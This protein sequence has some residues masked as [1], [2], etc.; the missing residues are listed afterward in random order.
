MTPPGRL[1]VLAAPSGV[2]KTTI[3]RALAE[4]RRDVGFSVSATTRPPRSG[5]RDGVDYHFLTAADF[6]RRVQ[7]GDF[8]EFAD[9][10][11][12]RYGTLRA[13]VDRLRDQGRHVLL[14]IEVQG[15]AQVRRAYPWP[16]SIAIFLLPPSGA[17]LRRRLAA[18]GSEDAPALERRLEQGR[19]ELAAAPNFDVLIVNDD[20]ER[21]VAAVSRALDQ[22]GR[23]APPPPEL[24]DR[25]TALIRELT[26]K[27]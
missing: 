13:E 15:A 10:A 8:L 26:G 24:H 21:A 20:L 18:R 14:D 6:E 16:A 19:R 7:A 4:R 5:E 27:A 25:V 3:A 23:P 22:T 9:Y 2:G 17:E 1:V 11:G 12:Q